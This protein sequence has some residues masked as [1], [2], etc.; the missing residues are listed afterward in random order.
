MGVMQDVSTCLKLTVTLWTY[1]ETSQ[2][3][4]NTELPLWFKAS[5]ILSDVQ[6]I[7]QVLSDRSVSA[8]LYSCDCPS[9]QNTAVFDVS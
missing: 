1:Q 6:Y 2:F 9:T 8:C 5:L 7:T 3:P 4:F